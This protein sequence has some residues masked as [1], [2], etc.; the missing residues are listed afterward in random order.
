[1]KKVL[2][3]KNSQR[4]GAGLNVLIIFLILG[5]A[6]NA[7]YQ[8]IPTAYNG[9]TIKQEMNAAVLQAMALPPSQ[10]DPVKVTRARIERV[11]QS[12][13][14]PVDAIV[15]V[16]M[17]NK[18]MQSRVS[19]TKKVSLL[20]FGIYDYDYNFDFTATSGGYLLKE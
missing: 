4:G 19:Y 18:A 6:G 9:E 5:L 12:N 2:K 3:N 13:N 8:Y 15:D 16:K 1:M 10:G 11:L 7:G 17:V 14:A 20:P